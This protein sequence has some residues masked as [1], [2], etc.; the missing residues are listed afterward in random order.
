M[1]ERLNS[2]VLTGKAMIEDRIKAPDKTLT[3]QFFPSLSLLR[4]DRQSGA[5]KQLFS[6]SA[7]A[8]LVMI[9]DTYQEIFFLINT[10]IERGFPTNWWI[11]DRND[12]ILN[13][14]HKKL[15]TQIRKLPKELK[16]IQNV[17]ARVLDVLREVRN[18]RNPQSTQSSFHVI[19]SYASNVANLITELSSYNGYIDMWNAIQMKNKYPDIKD[20]WLSFNPAPTYLK[21]LLYKGPRGYSIQMSNLMLDSKL[22]LHTVESIWQDFIKAELPELWD[23][24]FRRQIIEGIPSPQLSLDCKIPNIGDPEVLNNEAFEFEYPPGERITPVGLELEEEEIF[25]GV[26]LDVT[27]ETPKDEKI[28]KKHVISTGLG[29]KAKIY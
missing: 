17:G 23:A 18:R 28:T 9:D 16:N 2:A 6:E 14:E 3:F 10:H 7:D 24:G 5:M 4:C 26:Y 21:S 8:T 13:S 27:H 20:S 15:G 29:R 22:A 19:I 25:S 1:T 12:E 11:A